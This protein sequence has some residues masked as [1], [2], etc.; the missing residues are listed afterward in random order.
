MS[1]GD[2]ETPEF[3]YLFAPFSVF[4]VQKVQWS[5]NPSNIA[6]HVIHLMAS[7]DNALES[8]DLPT[9]PWC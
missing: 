6:P 4:T 3:E 8:D 1:G 9:A 5:P 2:E 7:F